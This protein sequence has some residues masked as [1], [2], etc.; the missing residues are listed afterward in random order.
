[1][2]YIDPKLVS[3]LVRKCPEHGAKT[4]NLVL[5]LVPLCP[6][7]RELIQCF[8]KLAATDTAGNDSIYSFNSRSSPLQFKNTQLSSKSMPLGAF[9]KVFGHKKFLHHG[10]RYHLKA[11]LYF[12]SRFRESSLTGDPAFCAIFVKLLTGQRVMVKVRSGDTC[13]SIKHKI[14]DSQNIPVAHQRLVHKG[15]EL[16]DGR[17]LYDANIFDGAYVDMQLRVAGSN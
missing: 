13:L 14:R 12:S 9:E 11:R 15:R 6:N 3:W 4:H 2:G 7:E 17:K 10:S 8:G 5:E 1:M 16:I